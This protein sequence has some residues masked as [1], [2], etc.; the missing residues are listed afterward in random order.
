MKIRYF[1]HAA[2]TSVD[3]EVLNAMIPYFSQN[4]GNPSSI[5]SIGKENKEII[6]LARMK[7]AQENHL[8][9]HLALSRS[10]SVVSGPKVDFLHPVEKHK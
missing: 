9:V 3:E 4:Y 6:S 1:D 5:Y 2:T 10:L 7:I 8:G